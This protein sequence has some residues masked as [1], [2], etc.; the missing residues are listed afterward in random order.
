M[1][2]FP[3]WVLFPGGWAVT[4]PR[5][6]SSEPGGSLSVS[7]S[8]EPGYEQHPKY[9]C[10]LDFFWLCLTSIIRTNGS[11]ARVTEGRVSIGDNHT[12]RTVT[13]TLGSV[14]PADAG[15]YRC[16]VARTL[17]LGLWHAVEVV[18]SAAVSATTEA[19]SLAKV[20]QSSGT[21]PPAP[22]PARPMG[23]T[24]PPAQSWL[25]VTY[26]LLF[27]GAK[28]PVLLALACWSRCR[29][30][31][32]REKPPPGT[33]AAPS[34][35]V[36]PPPPRPAG[37]EPRPPGSPAA[38]AAARRALVPQQS[39]RP[40]RQPPRCFRAGPRGD[41]PGRGALPPPGCPWGSG[42]R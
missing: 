39:L 18:V 6:V 7:C 22:T 15:W 27:L 16:G 13:V 21:S 1:R 26:L 11:E 35:R 38:G 32:P 20:T 29:S 24:D 30:R 33:G 36:P 25:G 37:D 10:R 40:P 2:I 23:C 41:L 3:I 19:S 34:R 5:R 42:T 14:V 12:A 17:R 28:V 8:Y 4:G 9:W 31:G